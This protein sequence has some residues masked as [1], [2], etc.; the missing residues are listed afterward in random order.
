MTRAYRAIVG[1]IRLLTWI[2][3][4]RVEVTGLEHVPR[5]GGG[6]LIAWH[7]NGLIDPCLILATFPRAVTFGAR[8]GLFGW[9]LLGWLM[10]ALG[11]VPIYRAVDAAR[12]SDDQ[13]R[14]GNRQSIDALAG[15]VA[16]GSFS[17]LFPEGVSHD[18]P[19]PL[20]LRTG[21]ARLYYRA[22]L[23]AGTSAP[24]PAIVP[25][26]LH[27]DDKSV[28]GSNVLVVFHR[29]LEL[30]P[31]LDV[32]PPED[33]PD[34]VGRARSRRLTAEFDRVLSEVVHATDDWELH[35]LFM[36]VRSLVRAERVSRS[37]RPAGAPNL[38]EI[39][40]EFAR[41]RAGYNAL[42]RADPAAAA[43]LRRRVSAYDA[44][45]RALGIEDQELDAGPRLA[46]PLLPLLL[47]VQLL[48]SYLLLPPILL[49]GA[50]VNAPATA[51]LVLITLAASRAV[52]DKATL[53]ILVGAVL[54][55]LTWIVAG[56]LAAR[57]QLSLLEAY[58]AI[59]DVPVLAGITVA[60]LSAAGGALF[61]KLRGLVL[62]SWRAARVRLTRRRRRN[63][64]QRLRRERAELHDRIAE[65]AVGHGV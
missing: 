14:S 44:D 41:V 58:P 53:K 39:T 61:L 21:A 59:P 49:F 50:L 25:V 26:A 65:V 12:L 32:T 17:A 48:V 8:H 57:G 52:K 54:Y 36:R 18:E 4:R 40:H 60:T 16:A 6:I 45:L 47:A 9:P 64:V 62:Q 38:E 15:A 11:T 28:F 63:A 43:R 42:V 27:Y 13:R 7:P 19:H 34:E 2:F 33:E 35:R 20:E 55:P 24:P 37:Q 51:L 3:F 1:F 31:E 23:L 10:R 5:T 56:L 30:P 29:P 46:S 22:R